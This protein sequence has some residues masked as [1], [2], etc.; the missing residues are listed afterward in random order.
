ML[1]NQK[2]KVASLEGQTTLFNAIKTA[3]YFVM[4]EKNVFKNY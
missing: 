4:R 3:N 1:N 2:S